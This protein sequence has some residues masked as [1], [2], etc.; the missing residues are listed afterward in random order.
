MRRSG[1]KYQPHLPPIRKIVL[2]EKFSKWRLVLLIVLLVG[3]LTLIVTAGVKVL[4]KEPGWQTITAEGGTTGSCSGDFTLQYLLGQTDQPVNVENN[5]ITDLYTQACKDAYQIFS[6]QESFQDVYNLHYLSQHPGEEVTVDGALYTALSLLENAGSR[7]HYLAPVYEI[8]RTVSASPDDESAGAIDPARNEG[9][10]AYV[11]QVMG[12]VSDPNHISLELLGENRVKLTVSQDYADFAK[13]WEIGG[14]L[15]LYWMQNAFVADYIAQCLIAAG[16]TNGVLSSYD[17]FTR[18]LDTAGRSFS[19][20]LYD[21]VEGEVFAA[22]VME[23]QNVGSLVT[24]RNYPSNE[25]NTH[26]FYLWEDG[27]ISHPYVDGTDGVSKSAAN[28]LVTWSRSLSCGE[29]LI[30]AMD[31]YIAEKLDMD[32]LEGLPERGVEYAL[33]VDRTLYASD[34]QVSFGQFFAKD[35]VVYR[36]G[37]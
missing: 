26:Y 20:N 8:S 14:Y 5:A 37:E 22:A 11:Q 36:R 35:D 15:D 18:N 28:D 1:R 34:T 7:V 4:T 12:F 16:H 29:T 19:L 33:F 13:T 17:G 6:S 31:V 2:P 10:K 3:G 27:E 9:M 30:A 24:F 32:A 25:L 23:Y 21:R